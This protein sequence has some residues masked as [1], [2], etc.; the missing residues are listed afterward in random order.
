MTPIQ[1]VW[2]YIARSVD[3][4]VG[5]LDEVDSAGLNW[6]PPAPGA[7]SLATLATH[8]LGNLNEVVLG[9]VGGALVNRDRDAEFAVTVDSAESIRRQWLTLRHQIDVALAALPPNALEL[10]YQH[11][12]RGALTGLDVLVVVARHAAE[13]MGQAELT[14]DLYLAQRL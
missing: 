4:I 9:V 12:R 6:R 11:P 2:A 5:C 8:I 7:N 13:H 1:A 3:R 10:T 14:R